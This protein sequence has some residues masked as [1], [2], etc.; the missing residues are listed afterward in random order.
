[1]KWQ[2]I[3]TAPKDGTEC[4]VYGKWEGE[5]H[6]PY[7]GLFAGVAYFNF[8]R[9]SITLGDCYSCDCEPTHWMPLPPQPEKTE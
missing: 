8:G 3:E 7:E 5:I 2:P 4:L 9:W 1:M 6:G